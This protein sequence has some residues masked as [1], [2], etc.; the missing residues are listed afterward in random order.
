MRENVFGFFN[1]K[2]NKNIFVVKK[3]LMM[4]N[5]SMQYQENNCT[6]LFGIGFSAVIEECYNWYGP[7]NFQSTLGI[8]FQYK[9]RDLKTVWSAIGG[10]D[11][12]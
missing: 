3:L 12:L 8:C 10:R 7:S 9:N 11:C 6:Q 1:C 5:I 2:L 4:H